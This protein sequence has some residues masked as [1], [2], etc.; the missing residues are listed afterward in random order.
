MKPL[1]HEQLR[2]VERLLEIRQPITVRGLE[3][4]LHPETGMTAAH[5]EGRLNRL[6]E[7]GW[8]TK[9]PSMESRGGRR[10]AEFALVAG[11]RREWTDATS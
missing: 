3:E 4:I 7:A 6:V 2:F 5:I 8:M 9:G 1:I 10:P 11:A